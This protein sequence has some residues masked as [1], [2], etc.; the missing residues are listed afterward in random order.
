MRSE[1]LD[2]GAETSDGE[3]SHEALGDVMPRVLDGKLLIGEVAE[4]SVPWVENADGRGDEQH[5]LGSDGDVLEHENGG[6]GAVNGDGR[7]ANPELQQRGGGGV[8]VVRDHGTRL[9]EHQRRI[10][11]EDEGGSV[12]ENL[13]VEDRHDKMCVCFRAV[14][15]TVSVFLRA[16]TWIAF[17]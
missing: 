13:G 3:T 16:E 7:T 10:S 2:Q 8:E 12:D 15:T 5:D 11:S 14:S 9:K 17:C 1:R 4:L 6:D